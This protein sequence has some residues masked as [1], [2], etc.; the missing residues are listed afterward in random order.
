MPSQTICLTSPQVKLNRIEIT[1]VSDHFANSLQ[2]FMRPIC[3]VKGYAPLSGRLIQMLSSGVGWGAGAAEVMRQLPGPLIEFTQAESVA[4]ELAEAIARFACLSV[5]LLIE[6]FVYFVV[7]HLSATY[8]T[9]LDLQRRASKHR[10]LVVR[11]RAFFKQQV[12][13]LG[14]LRPR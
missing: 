11:C 14:D 1:N 9:V 10:Q 12:V 7:V 4:E 8:L 3:D 5:R 13:P 2:T 6:L